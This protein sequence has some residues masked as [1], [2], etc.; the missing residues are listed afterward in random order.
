MSDAERSSRDA[1]IGRTTRWYRPGVIVS[2]RVQAAL[3]SRATATNDFFGGWDE[4]DVEFLA[5]WA[6]DAATLTPEP[7]VIVDWL[8]GRTDHSNHAWLPVPADGCIV[9]ADLPVPDDQIHAETIEYVAVLRSVERARGLGDSFTM[10]ELGASYAPWCVTGAL[11]ARRAG[12]TRIHVC[13]VEASHRS[14][15]RIHDHAEMNGLAGRDDVTWTIRHAAVSEQGGH[16]YFPR[17]DTALDNGAQATRGPSKRDYRGVRVDYDKVPAVTFAEL[18]AGLDRI[19]YVHLDLQGAEEAL[20]GDKG[21]LD[22]A[23]NR[24]SA[25]LLATQSRLIEGLA[26]KAFS[27]GGWSL[28]RERPTMYAPNPQASDINGWTT[29]DGA[30]FWV[31]PRFG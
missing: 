2:P 6:V 31:N 7:G 1:R 12:I 4:S 16:A 13:A 14:I 30:Q 21:F 26:L 10:F 24:V 27:G 9:V 5:Q 22:A 29:R 17:V 18:S 19:D 28:V 3:D 15:A 25:M 23:N 8:G 11:A 20:L